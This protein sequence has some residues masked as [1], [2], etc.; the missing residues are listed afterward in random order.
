MDKNPDHSIDS[1]E[2]HEDEDE[3]DRTIGRILGR[4]EVL[5][6]FGAGGA[7]A[8]VTACGG[9]SSPSSTPTSGA[10][11]TSG[12]AVATS[13]SASGGAATSAASTAVPSCIV[14]PELTEGPYFVEEN[15]NR[16]DIRSDP[17]TGTIKPG[18]QLNLSLNVSRVSAN[19]CQV[20][21]NAKVDV[22]HCDAKGA[23]SDVSANEG[24]STVGQKFLRGYQDTDANG[25]AKFVTIY[26][27]WYTGRAV[28][29]H[30]KIRVNNTEFTSQLFF[31]D[32][33][34]D[35]IL[36]QVAYQKSGNRI[37]NANDNI[38]RSAGDVLLLQLTKSGDVY[39]ATFNI[40][41]QA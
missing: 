25:Q 15:L 17:S 14:V 1:S 23:Y 36:T 6:L 41:I 10:T 33:L 22:W 30:F 8:L 18:V 24:G 28:H 39:N 20:L 37:R 5:V 7:A 29:I 11:Q 21:P 38:Y 34:S 19:A 13:T 27:G 2:Y 9:D 35:S 32:T 26:P 12:G 40:G 16:S 4:R 31:D 3:D